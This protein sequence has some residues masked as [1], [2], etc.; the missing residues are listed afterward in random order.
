MCAE[1]PIHNNLPDVSVALRTTNLSIF[2]NLCRDCPVQW[3]GRSELSP[4][5]S[6]IQR[7]MLLVRHIKPKQS[8]A[9]Q[10]SFNITYIQVLCSI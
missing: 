5:H 1:K 7:Y 3:S 9:N 2:A 6:K 10:K 4:A 8:R